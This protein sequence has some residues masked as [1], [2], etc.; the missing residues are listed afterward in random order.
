MC[1]EKS[2]CRFRCGDRLRCAYLDLSGCRG[3]TYRGGGGMEV[4]MSFALGEEM[5]VMKAL[6]LA[7]MDMKK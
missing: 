1:D 4:T 7:M 3:G 2:R 6:A 5:M